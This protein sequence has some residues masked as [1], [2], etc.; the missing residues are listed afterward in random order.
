MCSSDLIQ[1]FGDHRIEKR[2]GQF[3]LEVIDQQADVMQL[4]LMP[5]LHRL[6]PGLELFLQPGKA[7]GHALIVKLDAFALS[8]L[9]AV[10]IPGFKSR[11][12]AG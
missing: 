11:L 1:N 6:L 10:P 3:R 4:D 2:L 7:L 12:G 8:P 5:N 9:L